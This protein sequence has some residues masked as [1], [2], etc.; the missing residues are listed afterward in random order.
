MCGDLRVDQCTL[1][2]E[3][4]RV[5]VVC[6]LEVGGVGRRWHLM[7]NHT[8]RVAEEELEIVA[9][10][11]VGHRQCRVTLGARLHPKDSFAICPLSATPHVHID[12]EVVRVA[13]EVIIGSEVV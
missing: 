13:L 11:V 2:C 8:T 4:I 3:D 7:S 6:E 1:D 5:G 12:W 10:D 9:S